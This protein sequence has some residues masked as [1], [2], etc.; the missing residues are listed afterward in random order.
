MRT[1]PGVLRSSVLTRG[2]NEHRDEVALALLI[3][4]L[5]DESDVELSEWVT[6]V[7]RS[8]CA[9]S[10]SGI[11]FRFL[12]AMFGNAQWSGSRINVICT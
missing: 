10:G 2:A 9:I 6:A 8:G 5:A 4:E 1:L 7:T 3:A 12:V 11:R